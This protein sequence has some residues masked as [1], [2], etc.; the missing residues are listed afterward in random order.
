MV[1][2][3][4]IRSISAAEI[5]EVLLQNPYNTNWQSSQLRLRLVRRPSYFGY[6]YLDRMSTSVRTHFS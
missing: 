6:R 3:G 2:T 5:G 1:S 4:V